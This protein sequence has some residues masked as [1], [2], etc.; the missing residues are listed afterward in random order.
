[1]GNT[2]GSGYNYMELKFVCLC[3]HYSKAYW[4]VRLY[5]GWFNG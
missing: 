3:L 1:M 2:F 4:A 5:V